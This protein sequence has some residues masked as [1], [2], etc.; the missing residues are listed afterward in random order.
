M[1]AGGGI[2]A[3]SQLTQELE[4]EVASASVHGAHLSLPVFPYDTRE[5]S[6]APS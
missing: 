2:A 1:F 3:Q 4:E 5:T 6:I